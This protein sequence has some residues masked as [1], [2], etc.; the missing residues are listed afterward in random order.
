MAIKL[1]QDTILQSDLDALADWI[2]TNPKLT[3]GDLTVEVEKKFANLVGAEFAVFVNSG[4]S[5]NLMM[6]YT[7]KQFTELGKKI[8]I[9][10]ISWATDLAPAIQLGLEPILCDCNLDNLSVDTDHLEEIFIKEEPDTLLLVS[11]LGMSPN[12]DK[13]TKLCKEYGVNLLEDNCESLLTDYYDG[14]QVKKLGT[15]GKMSSWSTF[16][17]HHISTIEGGF[18]TTDDE[19]YYEMLLML[20]AHGWTRDLSKQRKKEYRDYHKISEFNEA[21]TFYVP[22]FNFRNTEIGAFLGLRQID[23]AQNWIN[24]RKELSRFFYNQI[25]GKTWIP[26]AQPS[27]ALPLILESKEQREK[28]VNKLKENDIEA[29]PMIAGNM[30]NQPMFYDRYDVPYLPNATK[31]EECGLYLPNHQGLNYQHMSRMAEIVKVCL[32]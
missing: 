32:R 23:Y 6:L 27:F 14:K 2:R 30:A 28:L 11:V 18:I 12:M 26:S 22:G 10:A 29:R 5:A 16:Y 25:Y 1:A 19:D 4:S 13:I 7:L 3:K 31:V 24:Y 8:V 21:Y 20:R 15:F 9:P 17:G